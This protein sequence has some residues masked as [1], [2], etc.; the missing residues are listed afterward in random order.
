MIC[1]FSILNGATQSLFSLNS[2]ININQTV[3]Y[4]DIQYRQNYE[5]GVI[6]FLVAWI[7]PEA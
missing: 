1:A 6:K 4:T 2:Y 5:L 3:V 7:D